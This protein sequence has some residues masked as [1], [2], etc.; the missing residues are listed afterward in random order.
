MTINSVLAAE[1]ISKAESFDGVRAGMTNLETVLK[2]PSYQVD[3]NNPVRMSPLDHTS[4]VDWPGEAKSVLVLGLHHPAGEAR[5]DWWEHGDTKG[6]RRLKEISD[7]I[8]QWLRKKYGLKSIPLPYHVEKGGLFLKD[9]AILSGLGIIGKNNLFLHPQFGPRIRLRSILIEGALETVPMIERFNPCEVC[10]GFCQRACPKNAFSRHRF[11]RSKCLIQ[12]EVDKDNAA[13][14]KE[15]GED[16][17]RGLVIK[18]C[19]ACELACPVGVG[20]C[21]QPLT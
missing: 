6:N 14:D 13:P 11:N 19:R 12:M 21:V 15:A 2:G 5:L 7:I 4:V 1:I 9:A 17:Q 10:E 16:G 18:Y 3:Q 20:Y 8:K